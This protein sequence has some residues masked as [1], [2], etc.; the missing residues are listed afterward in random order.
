MIDLHTHVLPGI[1]DGPPNLAGSLGIA[2]AAVR[3]GTR[4]MAATPHIGHRYRVV[5]AEVSRRVAAFNDALDMTGIPLDV[6]QGGELAA[7]LAADLSVEEL[8]AISLG[9]GG[10]VLLECPFVESGGVMPAL[11]AHLQ[12]RGFRVLLAHP[13]RSP[14]CHHDP[15]LLP[16]LVED[17]AYVQVTASSLDGQFGRTVRRYAFALLEAGL[18][19]VVASDAHDADARGPVL[20][21]PVARAVR[22]AGLAPGATRFLTEE[23]PRALLDGDPV[24][25]FPARE[26][27]RRRTWVWR[28]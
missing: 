22:H 13:E 3:A 5:P 6:V 1:D 28:R 17:G 18:V 25:R 27:P 16:E 19:H 20:V 8:E 4:V 15:E 9:G 11:V 24:P 10:C 23:A 12:D 14:E 7:S 21:D 26:R 2:R